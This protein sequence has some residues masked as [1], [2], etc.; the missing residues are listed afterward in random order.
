MSKIT[1][2]YD[3]DKV[4]PEE[5]PRYLSKYGEQVART[6]NGGLDF[7]TNLSG[8]TVSATFS[9]ANTDVTVTH[10]LGRIPTGYI[11]TSITSSMVIY[12]GSIASTTSTI[13]LRCDGGGVA[14][15]LIF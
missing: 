4:K 13:T 10:N 7:A 15:L 8:V 9:V 14:T 2:S 11:V 1:E 5:M 12:T 6:I 3:F